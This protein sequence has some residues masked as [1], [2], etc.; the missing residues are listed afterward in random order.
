MADM[1]I[2]AEVIIAGFAAMGAAVAWLA[3]RLYNGAAKC[4]ESNALL[5]KEVRDLHVFN[6]DTMAHV[7]GNV[8]GA[9]GDVANAL[10]KLKREVRDLDPT[11]SDS[12][13]DL[14]KSIQRGHERQVIERHDNGETTAIIRRIK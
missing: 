5:Q 4:E 6:R 2:P 13:S 14:H 8:T 9:I 12:E 3:I 11:D 1:Q 7:I 10:H